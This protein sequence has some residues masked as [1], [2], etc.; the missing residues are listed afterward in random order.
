MYFFN[1]L[2]ILRCFRED[3]TLLA[4]NDFIRKVIM[5]KKLSI[6]LLFNCPNRWR[7]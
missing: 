2:L 3:R 7:Q 1:R 5:N 4:V 6:I